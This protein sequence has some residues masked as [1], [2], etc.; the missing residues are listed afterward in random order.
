MA[1][2]WAVATGNANATAT[3]DGG[4]L[5]T[6]DDD[7]YANGFTV[8]INA[9]THWKSANTTP[10]T[11]AVVGGS[12]IISSGRTL[13]L[14]NGSGNATA[15]TTT[16]ITFDSSSG[17]SATLIG[18]PVASSL[19]GSRY[20]ANN[21]STGTLNIIGNPIGGAMSN[22]IGA[23]NSSSGTLNIT[24][25]PTG[26][27][28]I[29]SVGAANLSTGTMNVTGNILGGTGS[30]ASG[31]RQTQSGTTTVI[32]DATGG[33][34]S[35]GVGIVVAGG[36]CIVHGN[37]IASNT[38]NGM[39]VNISAVSVIVN[40]NVTGGGTG[41]TAGQ[42]IDIQ[43]SATVT[44]NGN[45][46]GAIDRIDGYGVRVNLIGSGG[47]LIL[48]GKCISN[49]APGV[50]VDTSAAL[51]SIGSAEMGTNNIFPYVGKVVFIN[52]HT[53]TF[54]YRDSIG[55]LYVLKSGSQSNLGIFKQRVI[56]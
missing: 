2:R 5:P 24:G 14:N 44:V 31:I 52:F 53:A 17:N 36:H 9:N 7:V 55:D 26:S 43:N 21:A 8:T 56:A 11:T 30:G 25:N 37:I 18:N 49:V 20:G 19:T 4:T 33:S 47:T 16:C 38:A 50:F 13:T 10:G 40:G 32:G 54:G 27:G 35:G 12:F 23:V 15:G 41:V 39:N 28:G 6:S 51:T 34:A 46:I 48:N 3:W 42:G 45:A 1:E 29:N 22:A